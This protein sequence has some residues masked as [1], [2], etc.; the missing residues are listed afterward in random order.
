MGSIEDL[1]RLQKLKEAGTIT[2]E[3][4]EKE[5]GKIL[6]KKFKKDKFKLNK[7]KVVIILVIL[8]IS[9][10][11]IILIKNWRKE[12][13]K[14]VLSAMYYGFKVDMMYVCGIVDSNIESEFDI[15][16]EGDK[17]VNIVLYATDQYTL[18]NYGSSGDYNKPILGISINKYTKKVDSIFGWGEELNEQMESYLIQYNKYEY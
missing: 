2:E 17:H 8:I 15:Y 13:E 10:I 5:K 12:R 16:K 9:I 18:Y 14:N 7:T 11:A 3:E 6:N 1:E 4:F